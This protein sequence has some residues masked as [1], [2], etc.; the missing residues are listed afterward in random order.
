MSGPV[1]R[2]RARGLA[3]ARRASATSPADAGE[4][5]VRRLEHLIEIARLLASFET[6]DQTFHQAIAVAAR[7]VPLESA[8]LIDQHDGGRSVA[9]WN[10]ER[11]VGGLT[12]A[13][14]NAESVFDYLIGA[15]G[16]SGLPAVTRYIV[17]PLVVANRP[18]FGALQMESSAFDKQ[19]LKFVN[20]IANQFA[21]ALDRDRAWRSDIARR[22]EAE[23]LELT[24]R[25]QAEALIAA[26]RERSEFL[27]VLANEL[28]TSLATSRE[29]QQSLRAAAG[30][31]RIDR[32][33]RSMNAQIQQTA[34]LIEDLRGLS[35]L[36]REEVQL[37]KTRLDICALLSRAARSGTERLG[38]RG[39]LLNVALPCVP[40]WIEA[41]AARIEQTVETLLD[42][43]SLL[44]SPGGR[45][46]MFA[47]VEDVPAG[48]SS[49][50]RPGPQIVVSLRDDGAGAVKAV[51]PRIYDL[52]NPSG[53]RIDPDDARFEAGLKL[54]QR[55]VALHGGEVSASSAG[56]GL[57]SEFQLRLP[58]DARPVGT[59]LPERRSS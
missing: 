38:A 8:I 23:A 39:Q 47:R 59:L 41:D 35:D 33:V 57:G 27:C 10:P 51:L 42:K 19:D 29:I 46:W 49:R 26:D 54:V 12:A 53:R 43:A 58:I 21:V 32:A 17:L 15:T 30:D 11:N 50:L 1:R 40:A 18:V 16:S 31:E 45:I 3:P 14:E 48:A 5:P 28:R 44:V 9:E 37:R 4:P 13:R 36:S 52:L 7:I 56:V 6:V 2:T 34:Q 55:V 25:A 22:A 20:A 24:L